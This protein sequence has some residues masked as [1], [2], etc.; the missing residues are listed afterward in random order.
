M[1]KTAK[2]APRRQESPCSI[3]DWTSATLQAAVIEAGLTTLMAA[4]EQ[5]RTRI[6]GDRYKHDPTRSASR[7]GHAPSELAMGG[8]RIA[9]DRPRVRGKDGKEV[10]LP[11]WQ[12]FAQHDPLTKRAVEQ[13]L[14]GVATRK[15]ARSLEAPPA[16]VKSRGTS[17]SAVSRRFVHATAIELE[18]IMSRRLS[19]IDPAVLV[20]DAL[21]VGDHLVLVAV[22][23]DR[24]GNKVPLGIREGATE[25]AAACKA[26]LEDLR[27]RG[28]QTDKSILVV[29]DGSKAL[30]SAVRAVFGSRALIQRCQVHKRRNV[31]EQL[32]KEMQ[33]AAAKT[34]SAAYACEDATTAK[35]MLKRL[36]GQLETKWPSAAASLHE[37]LDET[38]TVARLELPQALQRTLRSTN[39]IENLNKSIRVFS[40]NVDRWRDGTMVLRWVA[41]AVR[42]ATKRFRRLKG[43]RGLTQLNS[44][45]RAHDRKLDGVD[46]DAVFNA[47]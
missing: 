40:R 10:P 47:A 5:E 24:E 22:G 6:C 29:I 17:K 30:H 21:H 19:M 42:E 39:L 2:K 9:V 32:P 44:A 11:L 12:Y 37:G 8:H 7:A 36:A 15:Y 13:M 27:E 35:R 14:V 31:L 43:W 25:N 4:L 38:L 16:T 46:I 34:L 45:L 26:L 20:I 1:K 3:L 33:P 18:T 28:L 41:I 23:V